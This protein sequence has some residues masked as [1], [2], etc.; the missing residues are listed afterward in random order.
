MPLTDSEQYHCPPP[1]TV[2]PPAAA[3]LEPFLTQKLNYLKALRVSTVGDCSGWVLVG[4]G[5]DVLEKR[6]ASLGLNFGD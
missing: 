3:R 4:H 5:S 2:Y 1:G 6:T